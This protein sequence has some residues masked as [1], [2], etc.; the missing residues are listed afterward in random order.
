VNV[1]STE[2]RLL[3]VLGAEP[4]RV[5]TRAELMLAVWGHAPDVCTRTLDS[6][7]HRLRRKLSAAEHPLVI[8]VRGVGLQLVPAEAARS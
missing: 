5:F 3:C 8:N 4:T 2:Y 1:S 6:H 7:A